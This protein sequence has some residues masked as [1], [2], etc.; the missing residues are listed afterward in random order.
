M[1]KLPPTYDCPRCSARIPVGT[2]DHRCE[3]RTMHVRGLAAGFMKKEGETRAKLNALIKWL[4][5]HK[6]GGWEHLVS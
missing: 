2:E 6:I 3:V 1:S 4:N 5:D